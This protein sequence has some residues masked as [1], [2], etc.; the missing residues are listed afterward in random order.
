MSFRGQHYRL[1][2][3]DIS[4]YV[5]TMRKIRILLIA[6][7]FPPY[8][9]LGAVR[10]PSL[11]RYLIRNGHDVHVI[12]AHDRDIVGVSQPDLPADRVHHLPYAKPG[13]KITQVVRRLREAVTWPGH[14]PASGG[15]VPTLAAAVPHP[16]SLRQFYR[17]LILFPDRFKN[18]TSPAVQ[19]GLELSRSWMPDVIYSSCPPHAGHMVARQLS[20]AL[21]IPWIAELRDLWANNPYNDT[22]P[23]IK[24]ALDRVANA[25]LRR[26]HACVAVTAMAGQEVKNATGR[27]VVLSYNGFDPEEFDGLGEVPPL[28]RNRLTIIHA[29]VIYAGRRDPTA[30]LQALALMGEERHQ[31]TLQFYHDSHQSIDTMAR[32]LGVRDCVEVHNPVPRH[33]ILRREREADVLL[34]CRWDNP[35]EDGIIP[36][37]LFEYIGA[38]R[39]I[40]SVG[41][42]TGEAAD[43]IRKGAFGLVSNDP[44]DILKSLRIWIAEKQHQGGRL[45]DLHLDGAMPFQRDVQFEKVLSL[46]EDTV[47]HRHG[48]IGVR[49]MA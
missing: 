47:A 21:G 6:G 29:G 18:W 36:G 38:R 17:Q 22:H 7:F 1:R 16:S 31:V 25:T 27:P 15:G 4:S 40:L 28:D 3:D 26:A 48:K 2:D 12:A 49:T 13:T 43:I 35:A 24:P 19:C 23:L 20:A 33:E 46:V 37:K 9:P 44:M 5:L 14:T 41:S 42:T 32:Q 34:L 30:L 45:A 8:A 10:A 39:P 11:A